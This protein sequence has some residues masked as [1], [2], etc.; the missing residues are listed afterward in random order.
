MAP[1]VSILIP[2]FNAQSTL[3]DTLRSAIDQT[4]RP[5]EVIVVNDGSSDDTGAIAGEFAPRGVRVVTQSNGGAAAARNKALSLC[6]GDYIQWLDA[7]DLLAPDKIEQQMRALDRCSDRAVLSSSWGRFWH[8]PARA[9]F[10]PTGLWC[11]LAPLEWLLRKMEENA[12]MQ[13]ATWLVPRRVAEA[14]GP[15]DARLLVDDDGEFFCRV[16]LVS[17]QV[18]FVPAAR[19][20][21]RLS[22]SRRLSYI[23]RSPAKMEAQLLTVRLQIA[24]L[25]SLQDSA[26]A[27][28]ACI[29]YLQNALIA[30]YPERPDL[31]SEAAQLARELGGELQDPQF[32]WKYAW[33]AATCGPRAAKRA[34]AVRSRVRWSLSE[35]WDKVMHGLET[36]TG[37][38]GNRGTREHP[39]GER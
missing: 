6:G 2:A 8:R 4:W 18:G 16:L 32:P 30:F 9:Q 14:A 3:R 17:D 25:R 35:R 29:T 33:L 39:E 31:V 7:D 12:F 34:E 20:F 13:T 21:Y 11:D 5:T 28:R 19:V 37:T 26:R 23:G 24:H 38:G 10:K 1:L 15:W 22:G 36:A 27:R